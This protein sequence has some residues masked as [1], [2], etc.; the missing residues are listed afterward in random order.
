MRSGTRPMAK[1]T[2]DDI[3]RR[4]GTSKATVSRVLNGKP[5]VDPETRRRIAAIVRELRYVP[6]PAATGLAHGRPN[7][8]GMLVPSLAWAW[9]LEVIRGVAERL[10]ATPHELV[11]FTTS[12]EERNEVIFERTL[13]SGLT[14]GLVAIVPPGALA[15]ISEMHGRGFPVALI[16]D[17]ADHPDLPSVVAANFQGAYMATA[18]LVELGHRRIGFVNGPTEYGCNQE[19]RRGYESALGAAGLRS[20]PSLVREGDF[21]RPGGRRATEEL[22]A[23]P[24]P[25]TAIFAANDL[26]AFGA[27]EAAA[28]A[29]LRIPD[30]ISIVGFDDIPEA[31]FSRPA[32][33]TIRQ[34]LYQ[35]GARA[36][37]LLLAQVE[38]HELS[39]TRIEL[40]TEL[41][42]RETTSLVS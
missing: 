10:E 21:A 26:M 24:E 5:D 38:G 32:L 31:R 6:S 4:A 3:A 40:P 41:I 16:D 7:L 25:P 33:T 29:G 23:L 15:H 13:A 14:A 2:I 17:R 11:M 8:I 27:G 36:V 42:A 20:D 28:A 30:Q 9:V 39:E 18:H 37:D 1:P 34:P 19:R 35:M 22:L 12:S